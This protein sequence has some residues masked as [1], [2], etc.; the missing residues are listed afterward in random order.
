MKTKANWNCCLED[1]LIPGDEVDEELYIYFLEV[2]P[3]GYW[4]GGVFQVGEPYSHNSE[5]KPMYD[6]FEKIKSQY[7]YRGHLSLAEAKKL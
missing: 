3:P 1:Y 4:E 6:T 5:G 7:F 2:L